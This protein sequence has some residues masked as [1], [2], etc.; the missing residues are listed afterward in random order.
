L[1]AKKVVLTKMV[2]KVEGAPQKAG[3][4]KVGWE[5]GG[6]LDV[7]R[8]VLGS[9]LKKTVGGVVGLVTGLE[10]QITRKNEDVVGSS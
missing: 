6:Q 10:Y 8:N 9:K 7:A 1:N 4:G 2:G 3:S 5:E